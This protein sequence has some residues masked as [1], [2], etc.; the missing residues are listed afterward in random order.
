M[1]GAAA[2]SS[3]NES[4]LRA[5]ISFPPVASRTSAERGAVSTRNSN[6]SRTGGV[7]EPDV[8]TVST[9]AATSCQHQRIRVVVGRVVRTDARQG[10]Q[11]PYP[12]CSAISQ[13]RHGRMRELRIQSGGRPIR[14]FYAFDPRRTAVLLLGAH[15]TQA[16]R[17]YD[18]YVPR[19]NLIY[20]RHLNA[21]VRFVPASRPP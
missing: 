16:R 1:S 2:D 13:S 6:A 8:R 7:A 9:A 18:Y 4:A 14:V 3:T 5:S 15:K 19:A 12:Y 10:P 20:D 21:K 17:F 11:L